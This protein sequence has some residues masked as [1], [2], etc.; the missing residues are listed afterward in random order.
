MLRICHSLGANTNTVED[1]V[2]KLIEKNNV[3]A[4]KLKR[5]TSDHLSRIQPKIISH[6]VKVNL[7]R[8]TFCGLDDEE[9]RSFVGKKTS[10]SQ[11]RTI[12]LIVNM[13]INKSEYGSFVFA[14]TENLDQVDCKMLLDK[15]STL[16]IKGGG[17]PAFVTG[18]VNGERAESTIIRLIEDILSLIK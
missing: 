14:R 4:H 12:A 10:Q 8:E 3:N 5:L 13:P 11:E 16:G 9:I 17:R 1:T 7:I 6:D 15:Y 2:N 18:I